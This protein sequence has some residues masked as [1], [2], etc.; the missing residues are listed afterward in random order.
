MEKTKEVKFEHNT[1]GKRLGSMLKVDFRRMFTMPL[2]YI[3]VGA[4]LVMPIIIL[5]MTTMMNGTVSVNPQTGVETVIE[6]FDSV[7][8]IIGSVSGDASASTK[9]AAMDISLTSMCNVNMLYFFIAVL[10]CIFV[11]EDFRS[12]YAKNLFTVRARKSDYVV[13]KT[14]VCFVGGALMILAFFIGAMLGGAISGL[15]FDM[16]GFGA[17]NV[18]M[19]ILSKMILAA[20]FVPIYLIMSVVANQKLW[21][22]LILSFMVGML[23]FMMIPMLTP[24]NS[25]VMNVILCLAGGALFS[26]GLGAISNVVLKKT[27][28]V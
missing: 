14:L 19:C 12:G 16:T 1:F 21:L 7:W 2:L 24:L 17:G 10:V 18:M 23:L 28:L 20:V 13:S 8:Q 4:C 25:T 27:S 3:I 9:E 15:P 22:S 11:A 6:G 26:A 5:V